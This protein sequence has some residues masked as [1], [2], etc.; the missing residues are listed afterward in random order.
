[1][2]RAP[3]ATDQAVLAPPREPR[4]AASLLVV[5]R[6]PPGSP[7]VPRVLMAR[8]AAG[9]RFMP[10]VLVFPGGAV[11][12]A[13][14]DA[15]VAS[16]L[17]PHMR[18]RLERAADPLLAHALAVAAARELTE[19]VGLSLGIP[20]ALDGLAYL[21]R[22]ITPPDRPIRFDA[23][24]FVVDAARVTGRP[25]G[26]AELQ[27]PDWYTLAAAL[28]ADIAAP[29]RAVIGKLHLWLNN[30]GGDDPTPVLRDRKWTKEADFGGV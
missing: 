21:C 26:S 19:E 25:A 29:T 20:P 27:D 28:A 15:P 12:A 23:R 3:P 14:F 6:P 13:D 5:R 18:A 9:H 16:P 17:A 11:D 10:N 30:P 7:G 8:R 2:Q 24:F 1:M 4:P 22:A